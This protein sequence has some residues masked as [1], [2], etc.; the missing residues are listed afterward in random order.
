MKKIFTGIIIFLLF[1]L[2][3]LLAFCV[4]I[5]HIVNDVMG[6]SGIDRQIN[7]VV[8]SY[9]N[10]YNINIVSRE[11]INEIIDEV[12]DSIIESDDED[13]ISDLLAD[14]V[15]NNR[16]R[17]KSYGISDKDID[18]VI[19]EIEANITSSNQNIKLSS[20][21]KLG[22][23]IYK[24]V[25]SSSFKTWIIALIIGCV[26]ILLLINKWNG[27][28]DIGV[29]LVGASIMIKIACFAIDKVLNSDNLKDKLSEL[30]INCVY[31]DKY[32]YIYVAI[33]IVLIV[34]YIIYDVIIKKRRKI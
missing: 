28:K 2:L 25:S 12:V 23:A 14:V 1:N 4:N 5:K 17:L 22:L 32:M 26:I 21:Q 7:D 33:G 10:K 27:L 6:S 34:G 18:N 3:I 20:E 8:G 15:D 30:R 13:D 11:Q 24:Y 9:F 16:D 29:S 19:Y 31:F